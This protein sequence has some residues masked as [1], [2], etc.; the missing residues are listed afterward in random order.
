MVAI[1]PAYVRRNKT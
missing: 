1:K